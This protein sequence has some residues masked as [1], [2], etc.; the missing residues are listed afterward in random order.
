MT[1]PTSPQ[2]AARPAA[3]AESLRMA[4]EA[5]SRLAEPLQTSS[6]VMA[7][8][9]LRISIATDALARMD[10]AL[11]QPSVEAPAAVEVSRL[12]VGAHELA[13]LKIARDAL[14]DA[15]KFAP[16]SERWGRWNRGVVEL[17]M[18]LASQASTASEPA[19]EPSR[20]LV[21]GLIS[22]QNIEGGTVALQ[23]DGRDAA[24]AFMRDFA[25]TGARDRVAA[26]R[27]GGRS[28]H[29]GND[30][31]P[32]GTDHHSVWSRTDLGGEHDR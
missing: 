4:R 30:G 1:E 18:A 2:N 14:D 9:R 12:A 10:A 27:A 17:D 8:A 22:S 23:F 5:L 11:A 7:V 19:A 32:D 13:D 29:F 24:Q 6:S 16:D 25:T 31:A 26:P 20:T 3:V 21:P 15:L 28:K